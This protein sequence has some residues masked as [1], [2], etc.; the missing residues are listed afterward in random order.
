MA[1][2][3]KVEQ[4]EEPT[5]D[6][7]ALFEA[8]TELEKESKIS[9]DVIL[10][11]LKAGMA[12]AYKKETGEQR[13][14][15]VVMNEE[16]QTFSVYSYRTVVEDLYD[17]DTEISLEEAIKIKPT[18]KVGDVIV[19]P[20]QPERFSR[21]AAQTAKQVILQR[22]TDAKNEYIMNEMSARTG[23]IMNAI[24][25]RVENHNVFVEIADIQLEGIMMPSDQIRTEKYRV[26]DVIKVYIKKVRDTQYGAQVIVSRGCAGFIRAL[27]IAEVPE[28]KVGIV[29]IQN[30][31]REAGFRTKIAV[32]SDDPNVDPK[33]ACIGTKGVRINEI[34][35]EI[36]GYEKIDIV[37]YTP[38]P[39]EYIA[40][41]LQ[42]ATVMMISTNDEEKTAKVVVPDEKLSLAIGRNG[43][44]ARLAA[45]L[46]GYKIDVKPYSS[47]QEGAE[48]N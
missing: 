10:E 9:R 23:Q 24:V 30:I 36:G 37:E 12:S 48:N 11:A 7:Q 2:R 22:L 42:P 19:E 35:S 20:I 38:D 8:V 47:T 46:T 18:Y 27:F 33:T 15:T 17:P 25:R 32:Y 44:N 13:P 43:Q 31:V 29:K 39:I 4:I 3:K 34:I 6:V 26:G 21:I 40:Q 45:K 16:K 41:A 14:V 28:I 5:L 1:K